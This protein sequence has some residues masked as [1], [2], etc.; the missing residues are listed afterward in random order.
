MKESMKNS[1]VRNF[2][3]ISSL[4]GLL[5]PGMSMART[6]LPDLR[7]GINV[8]NVHKNSNGTFNYK[9]NASV[10]NVGTAHY[11]SRRNQQ[12]LNLY[13]GNS[14]LVKIWGFSR[15]N[16]G[17]TL[18]FSKSFSNQPGGEFV[19]S[20]KAMLSFDPDIYIDGNRAND[21]SN[22]NNNKATLS[23]STLSSAF[24]RAS[25]ATRIR[26]GIIFPQRRYGRYGFKPPHKII[27]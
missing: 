19:P 12:T 6:L 16:R 7:V 8:T 24:S 18:K 14:R 27:P 4:L 22:R 9:I 15:V 20:Y 11:V 13:Q 23:S 26:P 21:D 3:L 10:I 25:L 1:S 5:I 2:L 17:Q